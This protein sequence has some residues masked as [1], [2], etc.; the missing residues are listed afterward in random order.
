VTVNVGD[1]LEAGSGPIINAVDYLLNY[2]FDQR[3]SDIH[4][5]PRRDETSVRMRIDGVLHVVYRVP[6]SLHEAL[7]NRVKG[8][9]EAGYCLAKA[10]RRARIR[11]QRGGGRDG[12]CASRRCPRR[13]ATKS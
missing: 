10:A 3:A 6:R 4:I 2:A 9:R 1:Q 7:T 12:T 13:S 8:A 11:T 5:E